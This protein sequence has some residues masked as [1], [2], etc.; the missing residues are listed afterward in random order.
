M[1]SYQLQHQIGMYG[2][3]AHMINEYDEI[4]KMCHVKMCT[5]LVSKSIQQTPQMSMPTLVKS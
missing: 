2:A 3:M 5:F 4:G 1:G